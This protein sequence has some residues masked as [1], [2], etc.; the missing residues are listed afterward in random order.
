M[1]YVGSTTRTLKKRMADH[2]SD[3]NIL[4]FS[5]VYRGL[6]KESWTVE[7][8]ETNIAS[9]RQLREREAYWTEYYN[10]IWPHGFNLQAGNIPTEERN[11]K[12][13]TT[14]Q[15]GILWNKGRKYKY[16]PDKKIIFI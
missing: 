13:R 10:T 4:F 12:V 15:N 2:W 8:L 9:K 6:G 11:Q 1:S 16:G 7:F 5:T 14:L 3:G